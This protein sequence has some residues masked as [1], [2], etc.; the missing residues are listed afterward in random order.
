M[1]LRNARQTHK[2]SQTRIMEA[3][4][5][6]G[7]ASATLGASKSSAQGSTWDEAR[8]GE[9][10]ARQRARVEAVMANGDWHT[11]RALA[12]ATGAPEASVSARIR[13]LRKPVYGANTVQRRRVPD[14]N[15]LHEYRLLLPEPDPV[16]LQMT[17]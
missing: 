13:D 9:R 10:I 1:S 14:S 6:V 8:D 5:R 2:E 11:L 4:G 15:G 16:Q 7:T 12:E 17:V 3:H